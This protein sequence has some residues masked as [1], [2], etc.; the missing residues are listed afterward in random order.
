M[1]ENLSGS[2]PLRMPG[3]RT[4]EPH[5][6]LNALGN[7]LEERSPLCEALSR[8]SLPLQPLRGVPVPPWWE[9]RVLLIE[10]PNHLFKL[11]IWCVMTPGWD[12]RKP[13]AVLCR[14]QTCGQTWPHWLQEQGQSS[15]RQSRLGRGAQRLMGLVEVG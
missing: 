12:Q 9:A 2:E 6:A 10:L 7:A 4:W 5:L 1:S 3:L 11:D 15:L 13:S 8:P 14:D